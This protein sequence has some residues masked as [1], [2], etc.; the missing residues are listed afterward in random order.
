[1]RIVTLDDDR[2]RRR[3]REG[4]IRVHGPQLFHGYVDSSL[5]A[6]AFDA[7]G[8]FRTGDLGRS[9]RTATS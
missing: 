2:A 5:D 8:W 1:M 9:T 3:A 6:D 4:E 7:D